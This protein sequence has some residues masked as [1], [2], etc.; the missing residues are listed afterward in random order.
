MDK[1]DDSTQ[2]L[3][4]SLHHGD[5]KSLARVITIVENELNGHEEILLSLKPDLNMPIIG[6]TGP[7]GAGKSTL[8]NSLVKHFGKVVSSEKTNGITITC[9]TSLGIGGG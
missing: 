7:P 9:F 1:M 3:M 5:L 4:K 6:V 8:I 2:Q